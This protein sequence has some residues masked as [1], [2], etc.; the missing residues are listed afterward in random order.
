MTS[1][2]RMVTPRITRRNK[3]WHFQKHFYQIALSTTKV[4]SKSIKCHYKGRKGTISFTQ[5]RLLSHLELFFSKEHKLNHLHH[6]ILFAKFLQQDVSEWC[7]CAQTLPNG[8][9]GQQQHETCSYR[10]LEYYPASEDQICG[11]SE[12]VDPRSAGKPGPRWW[13]VFWQHP[14]HRENADTSLKIRNKRI[15]RQMLYLWCIS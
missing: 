13:T 5:L 6:A 2:I 8:S 9:S 1:I 3:H 10:R 7:G 4:L 15:A 14:C 12:K 11:R